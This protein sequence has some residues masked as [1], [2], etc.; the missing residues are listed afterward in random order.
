MDGEGV[1][2]D[3]YGPRTA[4]FDLP[5]V[6]GL[7]KADP[8]TRRERAQRAGA[9]LRDLGSLAA[10]VSEVF[11]ERSDLRVVLG[12]AGEVLLLGAPPYRE[13]LLTFLS[14]RSKLAERCPDAQYFDLRFHNRIYAKRGTE[15]VDD[16]ETATPK[17]TGTAAE[18]RPEPAARQSEPTLPRPAAPEALT[19]KGTPDTAA[20]IGERNTAADGAMRRVAPGDSGSWGGRAATPP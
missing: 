10:H 3:M 19:P 15:W 16:R 13:R 12:G 11:V 6:R 14:L 8:D 9:L 7:G 1:L 20:G 4:G 18:R 17:V 2:I 5:I